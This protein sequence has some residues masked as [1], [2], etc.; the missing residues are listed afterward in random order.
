MG[1]SNP[2]SLS[3][4]GPSGLILAFSDLVDD[5][6]HFASSRDPQVLRYEV[7]PVGTFNCPGSRNRKVLLH[8]FSSCVHAPMAYLARQRTRF[9]TCR[10]AM[11][12]L[13]RSMTGSVSR[14][15]EKNSPKTSVQWKK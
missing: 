13:Q 9:P 10:D 5:I 3:P 1:T 6:S 11:F 8:F 15:A 14:F 7:E 12:Q 4:S 2:D